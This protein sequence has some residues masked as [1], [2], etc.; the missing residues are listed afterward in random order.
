MYWEKIKFYNNAFP[1][2]NPTENKQYIQ[3]IQILS[4]RDLHPNT[5]PLDTVSLNIQGD[6]C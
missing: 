3:G 5:A 1:V 6:N 2:A 4:N